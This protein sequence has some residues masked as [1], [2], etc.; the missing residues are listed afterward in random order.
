MDA[1]T[2]TYALLVSDLSDASFSEHHVSHSADEAAAGMD[3]LCL[4][5]EVSQVEGD[6]RGDAMALDFDGMVIE[7][8]YFAGVDGVRSLI[9]LVELF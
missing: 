5:Y 6:A 2:R 4:Y 7:S 9:A 3:E 1:T 8:G